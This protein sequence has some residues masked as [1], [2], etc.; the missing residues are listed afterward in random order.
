[1]ICSECQILK[2]S[3]KLKFWDQI[4]S[5]I[6]FWV[7]ICNFKYQVMINKL[8]LHWVSNFIG[9]AIYFI[10]GTKFFSNEGI[11]TCFNV[12]CVLNDR[13]F[14]FLG[15]HTCWLLL[16]TASYCSLPA[17]YWWL[18]LVIGSYCLF[19]LLVWTEICNLLKGFKD[20][21]NDDRNQV[22]DHHELS[23]S[24]Q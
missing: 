13:N 9:L 24:V 23:E 19:P 4:C 1:M 6:W 15:N 22:R 8:D 3:G 11:Y 5:S 10:F 21:A 17:G 14:Y 2:K 12:E 16:V 18:P 7:K 20:I